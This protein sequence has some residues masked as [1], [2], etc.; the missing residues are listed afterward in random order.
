MM[1]D[2]Q[3]AIHNDIC[4]YEKFLINLSLIFFLIG[5]VHFLLK[6]RRFLLLHWLYQAVM[7][8]EDLNF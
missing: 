7:Q 3:R 2:K 1:L 5:M 6:I 8:M 4:L